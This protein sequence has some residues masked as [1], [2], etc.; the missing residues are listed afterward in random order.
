VSRQKIIL[1]CLLR[2]TAFGFFVWTK[3]TRILKQKIA[4]FLEEIIILVY[5]TTT[6]TTTTKNPV[7]PNKLG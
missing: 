6:T 1:K 7:F 4:L 5:T 2:G 3:I